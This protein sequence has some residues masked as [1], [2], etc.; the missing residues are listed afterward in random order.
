MA[1]SVGVVKVE[2]LVAV[3]TFVTYS[4]GRGLYFVLTCSIGILWCPS[5]QV[6]APPH[7]PNFTYAFS[8]FTQ[9]HSKFSFKMYIF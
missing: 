1:I 9:A 5:F 7:P 6:C 8:P 4:L 2:F 3:A